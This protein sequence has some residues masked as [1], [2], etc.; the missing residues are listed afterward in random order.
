[1]INVG[2]R[3]QTRHGRAQNNI[4]WYKAHSVSQHNGT[5]FIFDL[6]D[7]RT[8]YRVPVRLF[9]GVSGN[10]SCLNALNLSDTLTESCV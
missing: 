10:D 9:A 2:I 3:T 7:D 5:V 6:D 8:C 4:C 1:M